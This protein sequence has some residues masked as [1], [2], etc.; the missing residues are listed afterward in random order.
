M[1]KVE[2]NPADPATAQK[3][4]GEKKAA[5]AR[6]PRGRVFINEERCKGCGLCIV[7][8]PGQ[9]LQA[10]EKFNTRGYHPPVAVKADSCT[11]CDICGYFCPDYAIY[12]VRIDKKQESNAQK[13]PE[14]NEQASP[15]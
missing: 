11:G 1:D 4:E 2:E 3:P 9:V 12:S 13:D 6:K 15:E 7:F 8:C 10:S 14:E 5:V